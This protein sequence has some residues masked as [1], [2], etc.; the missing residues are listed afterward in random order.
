MSTPLSSSAYIRRVVE[1]SSFTLSLSVLFKHSAFNHAPSDSDYFILAPWSG[2]LTVRSCT[3]EPDDCDRI[4][5]LSSPIQASSAWNMR[6]ET[7]LEKLRWLCRR[8][9]RHAY[10]CKHACRVV[11]SP[12]DSNFDWRTFINKHQSRLFFLPSLSTVSYKSRIVVKGNLIR[13]L[14]SFGSLRQGMVTL[15]KRL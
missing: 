8:L 4:C 2:H 13:E 3:Y 14:S 10:I 15:R 12:V 11:F 5:R 9:S 1:S 7:R 6:A